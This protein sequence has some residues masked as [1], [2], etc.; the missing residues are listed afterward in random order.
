MLAFD[1]P[2][3]QESTAGRNVTNTPGQALALLNAPTFVEAARVLAER[4]AQ[5]SNSD[6]DRL[7]H[8]FA[9]TLQRKPTDRESRILLE[10]LQAERE[11]YSANAQ[12]THD[13][14][15][16]GQSEPPRHGVAPE[17]AAWTA[18]TRAI[19]NLHEF[20]TRP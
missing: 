5:H 7:G 17:V 11:H 15:S 19:L 6:T 16:T 1:A 12:D 4:L 13:L 2:T 14:L 10:L 18:V 8:A 3:R 20:L 9:I